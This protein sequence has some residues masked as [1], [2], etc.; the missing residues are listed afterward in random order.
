MFH[1]ELEIND[2]P[3]KY[4]LRFYLPLMISFQNKNQAESWF[5]SSYIQTKVKKNSLDSWV[6]YQNFNPFIYRI[7]NPIVSKKFC[8]QKL[9]FS[10]IEYLINHNWY[11]LI[12]VDLFYLQN[13]NCY[14]KKHFDH[15]III[16]GYDK[17]KKTVNLCGYCF[18]Q[19]ISIIEVSV[20]E[21]Y[22][23]FKH[24]QCNKT[25][26]YH[27]RN[28]KGINFKKRFFYLGVKG[29]A[30]GTCP[31]EYQFY[32]RSFSLSKFEYYGVEAHVQLIS[33]LSKL[34]EGT[35]KRDVILRIYAYLELN[36]CM[37]ARLEYL[38][39]MKILIGIDEIKT[40]FFLLGEKYTIMQ[41]LFI[42]YKK[43]K[44]KNLLE[45]ILDLEKQIYIDEK[46]AYEKLY[47]S[48]K[49]QFGY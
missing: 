18:S 16:S 41:N 7:P 49:E 46:N 5:M 40:D 3:I 47:M 32:A 22:L 23:A 17:A 34:I 36:R 8:D 42:K 24:C 39:N 6:V 2:A 48:C 25:W 11:I 12:N 35:C 38:E 37:I 26:I 31:L 4:L 15:S 9:L 45:R 21:L 28:R 13:S 44:N 43:S 19:K 30:T 20:D 1:K 29:Y 33:D 10:W 27:R 14:Q